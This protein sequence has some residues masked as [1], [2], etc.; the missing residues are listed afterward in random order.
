MPPQH[1]ARVLTEGAVCRARVDWAGAPEGLHPDLKELVHACLR[2]NPA[3]RPTSA[4]VRQWADS[5]AHII[6]STS[7]S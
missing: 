2:P 5:H 7:F 3:E 4:E 1:A 6:H